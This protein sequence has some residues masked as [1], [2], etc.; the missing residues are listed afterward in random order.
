[1]KYVL[2]AA[3]ALSLALALVLPAA[4]QNYVQDITVSVPSLPTSVEEFIALSARLSGDEI[5][6]S[7]FETSRQRGDGVAPNSAFGGAASFLVAAMVYAENEELGL[8]MLTV[9]IH[10]DE[11]ASMSRPGN[12]RGYMPSMREQQRMR[13]QWRGRR[14]HVP[15][16]YALG[17]SPQNAYAVPTGALRFRIVRQS[18]DAHADGQ[19]KL[20]VFSTGADTPRSIL[21]RADARGRYKA[22]N[23]S[24]LE[25][26]TRP[27]VAAPD[28]DSDF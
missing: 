14:A 19:V 1:M 9:A 13:Q 23:W 8:Q 28:P 24:S 16:T 26:G 20:F 11:R 17:T 22:V 5:D 7:A 21:M 12:Y 4:A 6:D 10:P 3:S 15:R 18:I 27:P 2:G 25:T